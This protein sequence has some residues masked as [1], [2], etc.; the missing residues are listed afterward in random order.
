MKEIQNKA[1][2]EFKTTLEL[3]NTEE[4]KNILETIALFTGKIKR[5]DVTSP[6]QSKFIDL[7]EILK[8]EI[9]IF[10]FSAVLL[11]K[12]QFN[13]VLTQN[14]E[15]SLKNDQLDRAD[16]LLKHGAMI[17]YKVQPASKT[18][19]MQAIYDGK[20]A[21][22][23]Y[24]IEKGTNLKITDNFGNTAMHYATSSNVYKS[25]GKETVIYTKWL[26]LEILHALLKK[27][28]NILH[29]N[30][31]GIKPLQGFVWAPS[32]FN[33]V[34]DFTY[35]N[36]WGFNQ[37]L[38]FLSSYKT[39]KIFDFLFSSNDFS[40]E[41]VLVIT[42]FIAALPRFNIE[43]LNSCVHEMEIRNIDIN[44][45]D[46]KGFRIM[47]YA[48]D[49]EI[50][51]NIRFLLA[52]GA[53]Q[54]QNSGKFLEYKRE[55][56]RESEFKFL[57][58]Y[59]FSEFAINP[60]IKCVTDFINGKNND[61]TCISYYKNTFY[62]LHQTL[63]NVAISGVAFMISKEMGFSLI[64]TIMFNKLSSDVISAI[65]S[66]DFN[67]DAQNYSAEML[68]YVS[69]TLALT[70]LGIYLGTDNDCANGILLNTAP[71]FVDMGIS[72][73]YQGAVM[74]DGLLNPEGDRVDFDYYL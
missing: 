4:L 2:I 55:F 28:V 58:G 29:E 57:K 22:A 31:L 20:P 59:V 38:E 11:E 47:D 46:S 3:S 25:F 32:P 56:N 63:P 61:A 8:K 70:G 5:A 1:L 72:I 6:N 52:N 36:L 50:K 74:M 26:N 21:A 73:M 41:E 19:L 9:I 27:G 10:L 16:L 60:G 43:V 14:L 24:L 62:S 17:D 23:L 35:K 71:A 51:C 69:K 34:E 37:Y 49:A 64:N 7:I 68:I 54:K 39:S 44:T 67:F 12:E 65:T 53:S 48:L 45:P 33:L 18:L 40:N 66:Y 13:M 15:L 42:N 30:N